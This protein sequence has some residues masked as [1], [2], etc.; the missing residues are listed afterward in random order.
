MP[1]AFLLDENQR[2]LLWRYIQ[3]HNLKRAYPLDAVRVGDTADLSLASDDPAVLLWAEREN[4]I[5]VSQD[6]KTLAKHLADHLTTGHRC[7]G[8]FQ[9]RGTRLHDVLDFLVCAAYA[10]EPAEWENRIVFVP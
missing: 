10:S 9:I 4:R 3:R 1:L 5:I 2:G 8:I 6:R 7:P